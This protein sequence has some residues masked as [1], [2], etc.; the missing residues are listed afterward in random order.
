M[1]ADPR[2]AELAKI[3]IA[4]KALALDDDAYRQIL[5]TVARVRSARD[6]DHAGRQRLLEHFKACGWRPTRRARRHHP[7]APHNIES[8]DRGPQ[9]R[10]IEALLADAG[11]PWS[12]ADAI[13]KRM[14]HV[15]QLTFCDS[16]QL[17]AVIAALSRDQQRRGD[18][19]G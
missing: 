13:A 17:R 16:R 1:Q 10:K 14:F 6:L 11:R 12:Y 8:E 5:W 2:N 4:K 9:M 19:N 3:H 7:G 18:R 15:D